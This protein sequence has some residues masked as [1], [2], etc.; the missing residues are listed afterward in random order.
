M[1]LAATKQITMIWGMICVL[2]YVCDMVL[3]MDMIMIIN[4]N[5]KEFN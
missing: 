1:I 3:L 5:G 4:L 2:E